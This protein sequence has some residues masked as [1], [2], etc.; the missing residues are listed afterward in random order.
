MM[1]VLGCVFEQ[2]D[3]WL[4]GVAALVCVLSWAGALMV[5][6]RVKAATARLRSL[7]LVLAGV[8]A[9]GG[10][11]ATHFVAMLA[12]QPQLNLGFDLWMTLASAAIAVIG[13]CAA[14][15]IAQRGWTKQ[16]MIAA[17]LA[18]AA[19]VTGLHYVG[20]AGVVAIERVWA[21]DLVV[22][23][24]LISGGAFVAAFMMLERATDMRGKVFAG[25]AFVGGVVA[26][27]FTGMGAL[28][29]APDPFA[30]AANVLDRREL[31][32]TITMGALLMLCAAAVF[33]FVDWRVAAEKLAGA[34]R[35]QRLAD[36]AIEGILLHDAR[37]VHD[38]NGRFCALLGFEPNELIG[39]PTIDLVAPH[40]RQDLI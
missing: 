20:M 34:E 26:L 10:T 35:M 18:M 25:I 22:A 37:K 7:W 6:E 33:S 36:A 8:A 24:V 3:L 29:V 17:G 23:S 40:S 15:E 28:T 27:H 12:Y 32:Q 4:V 30:D 2:H 9:G 5:L 11:W 19:T 13:A 39:S 38:V 16:P 1:R 31:A 14:F 21:W